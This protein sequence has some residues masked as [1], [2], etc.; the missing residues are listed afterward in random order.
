MCQ[1]KH[2]GREGGHIQRICPSTV[3][4]NALCKRY[5]HR[6]RRTSGTTI[7]RCVVPKIVIKIVITIFFSSFND[8]ALSNSM[9]VDCCMLFCHHDPSMQKFASW[10]NRHLPLLFLLFCRHRHH[11][12]LPHDVSDRTTRRHDRSGLEAA[13]LT[14]PMLAGR[15]SSL[16]REGIANCLV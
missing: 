6:N 12:S 9:F 2:T 10:R 16:V 1:S 15:S 8:V 11:T 3:A 4:A 14:A 13:E 5:N 7:R